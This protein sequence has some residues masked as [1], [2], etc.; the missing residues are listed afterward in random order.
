ME[1]SLA[2]SA[3]SVMS[4]ILLDRILFSSEACISKW[5]NGAAPRSVL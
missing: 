5:N 4:G 2:S 3:A 1:L